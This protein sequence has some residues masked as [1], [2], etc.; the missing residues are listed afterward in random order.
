MTIST[1]L[2]CFQKLLLSSPIHWRDIKDLV[3]LYL[4]NL[5]S[6]PHL[7]HVNFKG[8]T[9]N[10][11]CYHSTKQDVH[12]CF[13]LGKHLVFFQDLR[14]IEFVLLHILDYP[15]K[16]HGFNFL[17]CRWNLWV[18]HTKTLNI[19]KWPLIEKELKIGLDM[20]MEN[21]HFVDVV[22][23]HYQAQLHQQQRIIRKFN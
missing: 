3:A 23:C 9:H 10:W 20:N 5:K 15:I 8:M 13:M 16:G 22:G 17:N 14:V 19:E 18:L 12:S 4:T 6:M 11:H 7:K 1:C 2:V 21:L